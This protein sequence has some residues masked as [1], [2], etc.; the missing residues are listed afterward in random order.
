M[1]QHRS[2]ASPLISGVT[3]I[4]IGM[5]TVA[6]IVGGLTSFGQQAEDTSSINEMIET[7]PVLEEAIRSVASTGE[8]T[9]RTI[10]F[11]FQRGE[12]RTYP[13]DDTI[14]YLIDTTSGLVSPQ[15]SRRIGNVRVSAGADVDVNTTTIDG[16]DCWQITNRHIQTCIARIDEGPDRSLVS[17]WPMDSLTGQIVQDDSRY[18]NDGERGSTNTSDPSDPDR[19]D[20]CQLEGC[21]DFDGTDDYVNV[22]DLDIDGSITVMAWFRLDELPGSG[23]ED[24]IVVSDA[25]G[26]TTRGF[27]LHFKDGALE[28]TIRDGSTTSVV[29]SPAFTTDDTGTWHHVALTMNAS[30]NRTRLYLD[31]QEVSSDTAADRHRSADRP[32]IIGAYHSPPNQQFD[33]QIDAVAVYNRSMTATEINGRYTLLEYSRDFIRTEDLLV[34]YRNTNTGQEVTAPQ[35]QASVNGQDASS[36]GFGYTSVNAIGDG[37]PNGRV[38]AHIEPLTPISYQLQMNVPSGSDFIETTVRP[39]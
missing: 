29:T 31:G 17:Y 15:T 32:T 23:L 2:G 5:A 18:G 38:T 19:V 16:T 25:G 20:S 9:K 30:S 35:I 24:A 13:G 14:E 12:I 8:G 37:L 10:T 7:M 28:G 39:D 34:Q 36:H 4:G 33:G 3:Y 1:S 27:Q 22:S 11:N 21:L 26:S 6:L